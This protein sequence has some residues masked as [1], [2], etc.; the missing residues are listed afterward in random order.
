MMTDPNQ[1]NLY[2]MHDHLNQTCKKC[3][4]GYYKET[5]IYDD[6]DGVLHCSKCDHEVTRHTKVW[7]TK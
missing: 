1:L 7:S 2:T 4:G 6:W 5:S 3:G